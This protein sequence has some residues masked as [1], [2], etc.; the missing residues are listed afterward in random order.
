MSER[1]FADFIKSQMPGVQTQ[2]Q[3]DTLMM[4]FEAFQAVVETTCKNDR[5]GMGEARKALDKSFEALHSAS[6][7]SER[8]KDVPEAATSAA[9]EAFK[10]EPAEFQEH[11]VYDRLM[12][13][14][15]QVQTKADLNDWYAA[16]R[17]DLDKV[18]SPSL[19]NPLFDAIRQKQ[20]DLSKI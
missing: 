7:I 3:F 1:W 15:G 18:K 8:L 20:V 9:S 4:C 11:D 14:L 2:A 6:L 19:R 10:R 12:A 13:D 16:N 17:G 5:T